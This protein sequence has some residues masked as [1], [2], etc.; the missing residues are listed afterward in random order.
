MGVYV[1]FFPWV[2]LAIGAK[3]VCFVIVLVQLD[4]TIESVSAVF[5]ARTISPKHARHQR[6]YV[7]R[8]VGSK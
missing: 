5:F 4:R 7:A 1:D 3:L 8:R 2:A 6:I